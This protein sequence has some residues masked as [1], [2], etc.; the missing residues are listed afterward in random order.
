MVLVA[1]CLAGVI[2][3][4]EPEP[5]AEALADPSFRSYGSSF[6]L[7]AH[8]GYGV[9]GYGRSFWKRSADPEP[10]PG[11]VRHRFGSGF[12]HGRSR[13]FSHGGHLG[14]GFSHVGRGFSGGIGHRGSFYGRAHW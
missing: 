2:A 1:F 8:I 14:R 12:S 10:E 5:A 4:P 13:G 11:H 3:E 9:G 6:H 7:P